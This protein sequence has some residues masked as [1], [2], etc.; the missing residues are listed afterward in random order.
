M[1]EILQKKVN[2]FREQN[3][4][5]S[6]DAIRLKSLLLKLNVLTL[7]RPLTEGFSGMSLKIKDR[8]KFMLVNSNHSIGR[9]HFTIAHELYH[10]FVQEKF[11]IH[12]CKTGLFDK[13]NKEEYNA[14]YFASCL[15]M[16]ENGIYQMIPDQELGSKKISLQT[17]IKLEQYFAVSRSSMLYRLRMLDLL[18]V[19]TYESLKSFKAAITAQQYGYDT[20]LYKAG[21]LNV[22]VGDYGEKAK[23]LFDSEKISEGHYLELMQQIGV[24][25]TTPDHGD[26]Y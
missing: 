24:D 20:S 19:S 3:G 1:S 4:I 25:I 9:Q 17:V 7:F 23:M 5:S 16:P 10:L 18:N 6:S 8:A 21:N 2:Q 26:E 14:D 11:E 15:L 22:V 13:K 12:Q